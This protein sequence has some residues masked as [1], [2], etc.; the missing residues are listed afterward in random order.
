MIHKVIAILEN[1]LKA[2][3]EKSHL[4]VLE[5][6]AINPFKKETLSA[7]LSKG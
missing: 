7:K 2:Q 6:T 3:D 5:E 1:K 4:T